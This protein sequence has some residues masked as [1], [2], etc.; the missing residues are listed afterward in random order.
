M[1]QGVEGLPSKCEGWGSN[2]S[3]T[4]KEKERRK[5][6]HV[7]SHKRPP[8]NHMD[9]STET[10]VVLDEYTHTIMYA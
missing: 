7:V 3:T 1:A 9:I 8:K 10:S 2:T 5:I 6:D 4:T